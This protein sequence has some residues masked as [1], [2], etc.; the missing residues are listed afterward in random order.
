[1]NK[2][3]IKEYPFKSDSANKIYL[4]KKYD[5]GSFSCNCPSW[6]F[7]RN[8]IHNCRHIKYVQETIVIQNIQKYSSDELNKIMAPNNPTK[9]NQ[10]Q[11]SGGQTVVRP[12][13]RYF[14]LED[15]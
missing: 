2:L 1:M 11:K 9:I 5:D 4:V 3:L 7:K 10:S 13:G 8:E 15:E 12:A 14:S 6:T